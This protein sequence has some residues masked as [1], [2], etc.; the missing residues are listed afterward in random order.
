ME[1]LRSLVHPYYW[2]NIILS[3]SYIL[4]KFISPACKAVFGGDC[5][6][7]MRQTEILF[8]LLIVVMVRAR[9]TGSMSVVAYLTNSFMYCKVA[10]TVLWFLAYKPYGFAFLLLFIRKLYLYIY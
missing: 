8:F 1:E 3:T 4:C 2:V 9:K 10:N 6:V 5:D 7:E